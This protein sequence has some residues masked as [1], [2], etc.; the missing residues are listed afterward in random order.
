[1]Y[2]VRIDKFEG[3][4]DLLIYLLENARMDIYDI[5][6]AE[7]TEQYIGYLKEMEALNIEVDTEFIVLAAILIRL[8]SRMLLPRINTEGEFEIIEDPRVE[9][10]GRLLDYMRIKKAAEALAAAEEYN[11]AVHEKPA[12][13]MSV[14]LE[15]PD[16]IL[17]VSDE[18]MVN[19]FILFLTRRKKVEEVTRRYQRVRRRKETIEARIRDMSIM[20]GQKMRPGVDEVAFMELLP[21]KP[22]RYDITL[23]FMSLLSMI[24][25]MDYDA[26]QDENFGE[27]TVVRKDPE[28]L[29]AQADAE[30]A[31]VIEYADDE[32]DDEFNDEFYT[33]TETSYVQ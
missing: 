1:M 29:A 13:D 23:S 11:L 3:P 7:I 14:Y 16:E 6:V 10:R 30:A 8:K 15:N 5:K 26:R 28:I 31:G 32:F 2:K 33:E 21:E 9:L 18:Q 24:K 25:N 27:I 4:F 17:R 12:E 19:A 20:L 22:D